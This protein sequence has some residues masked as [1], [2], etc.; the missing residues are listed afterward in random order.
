M[1]HGFSRRRST[2][3]SVPFDPCQHLERTAPFPVPYPHTDRW[4]LDL[5]R[6]RPPASHE[7]EVRTVPSGADVDPVAASVALSTQWREAMLGFHRFG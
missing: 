3:H 6:W 4:W 7:G 2:T 5:S 1:T